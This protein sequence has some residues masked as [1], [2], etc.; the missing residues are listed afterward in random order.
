MS[1]ELRQAAHEIRTAMTPIIQGHMD[2]DTP[3]EWRRWYLRRISPFGHQAG[4]MEAYTFA[5][6]ETTIPE[7]IKDAYH[8]AQEALQKLDDAIAAEVGPW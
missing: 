4:L 5:A 3:E 6:R 7:A 1:E 8:A 2:R